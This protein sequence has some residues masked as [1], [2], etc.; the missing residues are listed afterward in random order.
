MSIANTVLYNLFYK[1]RDSEDEYYHEFAVLNAI[2]FIQAFNE[3][4]P[5]GNAD[6]DMLNKFDDCVTYIRDNAQIY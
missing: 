4:F 1:Y 6:L 3:K 2:Y 5:D